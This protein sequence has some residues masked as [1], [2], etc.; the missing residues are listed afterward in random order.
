LCQ[1]L[2]IA[3]KQE[4]GTLKKSKSNPEL[5]IEELSGSDLRIR[6]H[7]RRDYQYFYVATAHLPCGCGFPC[8]SDTSSRQRRIQLEDAKS[9]ARLCAFLRPFIRGRN[10]VQLYLCWIGNEEEA[11]R[12][13]REVGLE[14]LGQSGFA[15]RLREMLSVRAGKPGN[16]R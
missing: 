10:S 14:E 7:F 8:A 6:R 15:F 16:A 3:S 4:L 2:Y 1:R 13:E 12:Q 9:A 11:P 5:Q